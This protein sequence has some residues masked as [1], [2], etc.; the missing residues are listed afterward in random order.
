MEARRSARRGILLLL[1][2]I[3]VLCDSTLMV[4]PSGAHSK[5]SQEADLAPFSLSRS[6]LPTADRG[7]RR[8]LAI[9][10]PA[11]GSE[12][13]DRWDNRGFKRHLESGGQLL[14]WICCC[15]EDCFAS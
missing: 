6:G 1:R 3:L 9:L 15:G 4:R 5:L 14:V 11:Y 10:K 2:V 7:I 8:I 13:Q 12:C